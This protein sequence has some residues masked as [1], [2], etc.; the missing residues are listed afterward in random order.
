MPFKL[1]L[2]SAVLGARYGAV[3]GGAAGLAW[4]AVVVTAG[5]RTASTIAAA[6]ARMVLFNLLGIGRDLRNG[7]EAAKRVSR[8]AGA[9]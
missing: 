7:D 3:C 9:R 4:P 1:G 6:V 8:R 5:H 2:P